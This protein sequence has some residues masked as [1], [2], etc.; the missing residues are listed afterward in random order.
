M[1]QV[2][3]GIF[4]SVLLVSAGACTKK[5]GSD[6]RVLRLSM[7]ADAKNFDPAL[8]EDYYTHEAQSMVY[9]GLVEYEYLKRPHMLKPLL[10]EAMPEVSNDG[11]TYTFKIK[12]GVK[13]MDHPA[14]PEGKGREVKAQDFIYSFMRVA[15]PKSASTGFWIF[16][17]HIVGL[18]EWR[19]AQEKSENSDLMA[20]IEGFKAIDDYTLQIKVKQKY[21]QL[22]FVLA[23]PMGFVVAKEVVEKTGKEFVSNPV[24][25]GPYKL[26]SWARNSKISFVRNP[27]W[28][29]D[30]Y[31]TEG[32][33][34][35]TARGFLADAGKPIPFVDKVDL[36]IYVEEQP[37]W[38]N[39]VSGNTDTVRMPKDYF[40]TAIDPATD[41]LN[42]ELKSKGL[43][44]QKVPE[45][46]VTYIAFNM[47]DP[48]I[49]KG[50]ANLR[51]AIAHAID[52]KRN[53]ALFYNN[54]GINA[55]SPVPPGLA[56][57][58]ENYQ[59]PNLV[60]DLAKAKEYLKKAGY[61]DGKGLTL[62]YETSQGTDS[63]QQAE[64][65]QKELSAIGVKLNINVN[66]FSEL[67]EKINKKKAQMWGI[68][69]IADY[70]DVEN[71]LQLLYGP[72]KAPSPNGSNFD[73]PRFNKLFEQVRGM[74]DSPERRKLISD[75]IKIFE[76]Q[77]PWIPGVHRVA[78]FLNSGRLK[79]Y[80]GG[81][82]GPHQPA[83]FFNLA[84][85]DKK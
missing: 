26:A 5:G 66:Q 13:F 25:T 79:N 58:D 4:L 74:A 35:D 24:G 72:N 80:K 3:K 34:E 56:G 69:W 52:Y 71:F 57:Y 70:P 48:L 81:Y 14:F 44:R 1:N 39:F 20:P 12:K 38:L 65:L 60:Y 15:D 27:S 73:D 17:N 49:K 31:P 21:P 82:M 6:D 51:K 9:E 36:M 67:T 59:N 28:R 47:E 23:M 7:L 29:G 22:L 68:A 11:L 42:A 18:N 19:A 54:Q 33:P 61:P 41:D 45:P 50:G 16:D 77:M 85:D 63:R 55:Q 43:I 40:K 84:T 8:C 78:S 76:E 2:V 32:E 83:K 10:A 62:T 46:D 75:M 30:T 64:M 53:L 37:R